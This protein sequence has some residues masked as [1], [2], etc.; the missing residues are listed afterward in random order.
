MAAAMIMTVGLKAYLI[1]QLTPLFIS[2]ALGVW[3][4]Y[5]Q[6]QFEGVRWE[7]DDGWDFVE[8]SL[9]G[10]SY[11]KL[12]ALMRWFSGSIGFHHVHHLNPR[13]PNYNLARCHNNV[14]PLQ[15]TR[16]LK[17]FA[18]LKALRYRLWDEAGGRLISFREAHRWR[19]HQ[20]E[21]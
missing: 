5:I 13:I 17:I 6:H 9:L 11:Y 7:R 16:P 4:F 12:P 14:A 18:S 19:K 2:H 3:L 20:T 1:F 10:G 8:A 21:R 15:M